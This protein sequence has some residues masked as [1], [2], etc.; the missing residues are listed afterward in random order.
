MRT[1]RAST[2]FTFHENNATASVAFQHVLF[3]VEIFFFVN[4]FLVEK[5]RFVAWIAWDALWKWGSE[6]ER[7][8][9]KRRW[10]ERNGEKSPSGIAWMINWQQR[11]NEAVRT[12]GTNGWPLDRFNPL[13]SFTAR[14]R[15]VSSRAYTEYAVDFS[16]CS[17]GI[18]LT[19]L[20]RLRT[21]ANNISQPSRPI[22]RLFER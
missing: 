14:T 9:Q 20:I 11:W 2:Q 5:F 3:F 8:L 4:F 19:M 22:A 16:F 21:A 13:V 10:S 12:D 18:K 1:I 7:T 15:N 17:V 6:M